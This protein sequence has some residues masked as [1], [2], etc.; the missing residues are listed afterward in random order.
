MINSGHHQAELAPDEVAGAIL[1]F[2]RQT[3][4]TIAAAAISMTPATAV[5]PTRIGSVFQIG[6]PS[7]TTC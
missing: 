3:D 6:R 5:T 4:T 1:D 2:L 7:G